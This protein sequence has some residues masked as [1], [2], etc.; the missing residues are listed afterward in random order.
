[1]AAITLTI[2]SALKACA[3][4]DGIDSDKSG[5]SDYS[6]DETSRDDSEYDGDRDTSIA[7]YT[8]SF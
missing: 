1:M 7:Y 3:Y 6:S 8:C 2:N 4:A 5:D